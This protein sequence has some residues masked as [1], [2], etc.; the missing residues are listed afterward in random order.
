MEVAQRE[1]GDGGLA[2]HSRFARQ[3]DEEP[4]AK[5]RVCMQSTT[6]GPDLAAMHRGPHLTCVGHLPGAG[7]P[8]LAGEMGCKADERH[9][10]HL[11]DISSG[12]QSRAQRRD[13][14]ELSMHSSRTTAKSDAH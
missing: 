9:V 11:C 14:S 8:G 6:A 4:A 3:P 7:A 12:Q 2:A 1:S 10:P 5:D 13:A